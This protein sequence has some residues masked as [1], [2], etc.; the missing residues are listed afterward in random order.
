MIL[1]KLSK[2]VTEK[3]L[4]AKKR[5][6]K[7]D[8][9]VVRQDVF[10]PQS[11]RMVLIF[12]VSKRQIV[13]TKNEIMK[14]QRILQ[15]A[16]L[17][18]AMSGL[19]TQAALL[20]TGQNSIS[21]YYADFSMASGLSVGYNATTKVFTA[22]G[23]N[24]AYTSGY[25]SAGTGFA[26]TGVS[27]VDAQTG[28]KHGEFDGTG[29][30]SGSYTLSANIGYDSAL[31]QWEVTGGTITINGYLQ[32]VTGTAS[33]GTS[34]L[35]L[36]ANLKTG[37]NTLG[38][39]ASGSTIFDFLFTVSGG[40]PAILKDF[41]G[42]NNGQGAVI[43]NAG[44]YDTNPLNVNNPGPGTTAFQGNFNSSF[45]NYGH[46]TSATEDTFVPEPAAYPLAASV[47]AFLGF[48]KVA[49]SRRKQA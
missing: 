49:I 20:N 3:I 48:A 25:D 7:K 35:L 34:E 10:I 41:F 33:T 6:L 15:L 1:G 47:F 12:L 23:S 38:Y 5:V 44:G 46:T 19:S 24:L 17:C 26:A 2:Y 14:K 28:I 21:P 32:G 18:S 30:S 39:G 16:V 8:K 22:T 36:S 45:N 31:S 11:A 4:R 13:I 37:A 42:I 27:I 40:D 29:I 43:I 9:Q